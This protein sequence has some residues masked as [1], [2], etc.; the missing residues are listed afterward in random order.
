[1]CAPNHTASGLSHIVQI[2]AQSRS[3]IF[4]RFSEAL[5]WLLD[6]KVSEIPDFDWWWIA[7]LASLLW[8]VA[9]IAIGIVH[10]ILLAKGFGTVGTTLLALSALTPISAALVI[11]TR[12]GK[13]PTVL[14]L[15]LAP[16]LLP[17]IYG[18]MLYSGWNMACG[19]VIFL[20]AMMI[21][22]REDGFLSQPAWHL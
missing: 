19:A 2:S 15:A 9:W 6:I 4:A 20:I 13:F 7:V 16:F 8:A 10:P 5:C 11:A 12:H 21:F 18:W 14:T 22:C 3:V 17:S 1:M